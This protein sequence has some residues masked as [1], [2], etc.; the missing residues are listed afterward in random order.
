MRASQTY[1]FGYTY[2]DSSLQSTGNN[3]SNSNASSVALIGMLL[4]IF[5]TTCVLVFGLLLVH[6]DFTYSFQT[7]NDKLARRK[8]IA[9]KVI[10]VSDVW[11]S[12]LSSPTLIFFIQMG[13]SLIDLYSFW[14]N[15]IFY[16]YKIARFYFQISCIR[17]LLHLILLLSSYFTSQTDLTVI[18]IISIPVIWQIA[19]YILKFLELRL[20]HMSFTNLTNP[21]MVDIHLRSIMDSIL[22]IQHSTYLDTE[23][24]VI[25]ESILNRHRDKCN[26]YKVLGRFVY[27]KGSI[28]LQ[29]QEGQN[30]RH[31]S[32]CSCKELCQ[33]L[34]NI[35]NNQAIEVRKKLIHLY[36][37]ENYLESKNKFSENICSTFYYLAYQVEISE[38]PMNALILLIE[39]EII[40]QKKLSLHYQM[41]LADLKKKAQTRF[42]NQQKLK[43]VLKNNLLDGIKYDF[44]LQNI[45]QNL[46]KCLNQLKY[47]NN[48]LSNDYIDL[49]NLHEKSARLVHDVEE[50]EKYFLYV[51]QINPNS[52]QLQYYL[53][54]YTHIF[55][56]RICN[57]QNIIKSQQL[58][59]VM[60]VSELDLNICDP[61]NCILFVSLL[62]EIGQIKLVTRNS[63]KVIGKPPS[64]LI[65]HSIN[66]IIPSFIAKFHDQIIKNVIKNGFLMGSNDTNLKDQNRYQFFAKD[67]KN[68][69]FPIVLQLKLQIFGKCKD[70]GVSAIIQRVS[71][72]SNQYI[73]IDQ[74]YSLRGKAFTIQNITKTLYKICFKKVLGDNQSKLSGL[75]INKL[76]PLMEVLNQ[77]D[78]D[79]NKIGTIMLYPQTANH[80]N[81]FKK[82]N[83]MLKNGKDI[84]WFFMFALASNCGMLDIDI[85][86][87]IR[88]TQIGEIYK[89]IEITRIKKIY[90]PG[91]RLTSMSTLKQELSS[92]MGVSIFIGGAQLKKTF[93]IV[94]QGE[95]GQ[96]NQSSFRKFQRLA[97]ETKLMDSKDGQQSFVVDKTLLPNKTKIHEDDYQTTS[98][99]EN[100]EIKDPV[101]FLMKSNPSI[102]DAKSFNSSQ[103]LSFQ[104]NKKVD[105]NIDKEKRKSNLNQKNGQMQQPDKKDSI[106][107]Q[108]F[109][110]NKLE[111]ANSQSEKNYSKEQI[112]ERES[113]ESLYE[114]E[115][116]KSQK[117]ANM[118]NTLINNSHKLIQQFSILDNQEQSLYFHQHSYL[119]QDQ[120]SES[121]RKHLS[122]NYGS[123]SFIP[124]SK[125]QLHQDID[126][127]EQQYTQ[128]LKEQNF[129]DIQENVQ[130]LNQFKEEIDLNQEKCNQYQENSIKKK[131]YQDIQEN[132]VP[133]VTVI[134][135]DLQVIETTQFQSKSELDRIQTYQIENESTQKQNQKQFY[136]ESERILTF[137]T[138]IDDEKQNQK[139]IKQLNEQEKKTDKNN[140]GEIINGSMQNFE[141]SQDKQRGINPSLNSIQKGKVNLDDKNGYIENYS[142][143]FKNNETQGQSERILTYQSVSDIQTQISN[144]QTNK[145][146]SEIDPSSKFQQ[147]KFTQNKQI[148]NS[149]SQAEKVQVN[150]KDKN[151]VENKLKT[152]N[153]NKNTLHELQTSSSDDSSS[154]ESDSNQIQQ[155]EYRE[156]SAIQTFTIL[157]YIQYKETIQNKNQNQNIL[158]NIVNEEI[159]IKNQSQQN[160]IASQSKSQLPEK[161]SDTKEI[162]QVSNS[163]VQTES[164][165]NLK[166]TEEN[167]QEQ[168]KIEQ[169]NQNE[170]TVNSQHP[171][172]SSFQDHQKNKKSFQKI[173]TFNPDIDADRTRSESHQINDVQSEIQY[174]KT[175]DHFKTYDAIDSQYIKSNTRK[176]SSD[177]Q[178]HF[179]FNSNQQ[180][181]NRFSLLSQNIQNNEKLIKLQEVEIDQSDIIEEITQVQSDQAAQHNQIYSEKNI[182]KQSNELSENKLDN[183]EFFDDHY[184]EHENKEIDEELND[185]A[186]IFYQENSYQDTGSQVDTFQEKNSDLKSSKVSQK[187]F[188][189]KEQDKI[190]KQSIK[191]LF[192]VQKKNYVLP[193][194]LDNTNQDL[195]TEDAKSFDQ[196]SAQNDN[197]N[198]EED[199][200]QHARRLSNL[201]SQDNENYQENRRR[202][203]LHEQDDNFLNQGSNTYSRKSNKISKFIFQKNITVSQTI[204][205][206]GYLAFFLLIFFTLFV[207]F[208]LLVQ[209]QSIQDIIP[210]LNFGPN[211]LYELSQVIMNKEFEYLS[212]Y[213]DPSNQQIY[214]QSSLTNRTQT[215]LNQFRETLSQAEIIQSQNLPSQSIINLKISYFDENQSQAPQLG[216]IISVF[217]H[218]FLIF[219]QYTNELNG[220][221]PLKIVHLNSQ[222]LLN[223]IQQITQYFYNWTLSQLDQTRI[224]LQI[225]TY[226][227]LT[228]SGLIIFVIVPIYA[229]LQLLK[230]KIMQQFA[231]YSCDVIN[232]RN[233]QIDEM[234]IILRKNQ[235]RNEGNSEKQLRNEWKNIGQTQVKKK[236]I[237]RTNNLKL[238]NL[239]LF[240]FSIICLL[241]LSIY[242]LVNY[243]MTLNFL[244]EYRLFINELSILQNSRAQMIYANAISFLFLNE[245]IDQLNFISFEKQQNT[246]DQI[247]QQYEASIQN[248]SNFQNDFSSYLR[249]QESVQY[250]ILIDPLITDTC[251]ALYNIKN[252]SVYNS[253]VFQIDFDQNSCEQV[254]YGI[255]SQG[256][257][258]SLKN[259]MLN[260]QDIW[261]FIQ[262]N[263]N[264]SSEQLVP[265]FQILDKSINISQ[266][267]LLGDFI[268]LSFQISTVYT[269]QVIKLFFNYLDILQS[270]LLT[271]SL[272]QLLL[273]IIF[274]WRLF[275]KYIQKEII[276]VKSFYSL[277][278]NELVV[279]NNY[280][281]SFIKSYYKK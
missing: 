103:R 67:N 112:F 63:E 249:Y 135:D 201:N 132:K 227:I 100:F 153:Q 175:I 131:S 83:K 46:F 145:N 73:L 2:I 108:Q 105:F 179:Q 162:Q 160:I 237:S 61:K 24:G 127:D 252:L 230:E 221:E 234:L 13:F 1:I 156:D 233:M 279:N 197:E 184:D 111:T 138:R 38:S 212:Q 149:N 76:I 165:K 259:M 189:T 182:L 226:S 239:G 181:N 122:F 37:N 190:R 170:Q 209:Q 47:I 217:E 148:I 70:F 164:S 119:D 146:L 169:N 238:W 173:Q 91:D 229:R 186:K 176:L 124:H 21:Q 109:S 133:T 273:F 5:N 59:N 44:L 51:Y 270:C 85:N 33:I 65:S 90:K 265:N 9:S 281:Y 228:I 139:S 110:L 235:V 177:T 56:L 125:R 158:Q 68:Y 206:V 205:K 168:L 19:T 244:Q 99:D 117:P 142:S 180:Q 130:Q 11:I 141:Q 272:I 167:D 262:I 39:Y 25:F 199:V 96:H 275:I 216:N 154:K 75:D 77:D 251:E 82:N 204:S 10:V 225:G 84:G 195:N 254:K 101:Q 260:T 248:L 257:I 277:L 27:S 200:N 157:D 3:T 93:E 26:Q 134:N 250:Q 242:P 116:I 115:S 120:K 172:I 114:Q 53:N 18:L 102:K 23:K 263:L 187:K 78:K 188:I 66:S 264:K 104:N 269:Q 35:D 50:L 152:Q 171:S 255:L 95:S 219:W 72:Q 278:S 150:K 241:L 30:Q 215:Q 29:Q 98:S 137:Q 274:G 166:S 89:E 94:E 214:N 81:I 163:S 7:K 42:D 62:Q 106:N 8:S 58:D 36:L 208:S 126:Q 243:F 49:Y 211:M 86:L 54:A 79:R 14:R 87:K 129:N 194:N 247:I 271:Y 224:Y 12:V 60:Q 144:Q 159:N 121:I 17:L 253:N 15:M 258:I 223:D 69:I 193:K 57:I 256:I 34:K 71:N 222:M 232:K 16:D 113:K 128:S 246:T 74:K 178:S 92:R 267:M 6:H 20:P 261:N 268:D 22:N 45:D 218:L 161:I 28:S 240:V 198:L 245:Q 202:S 118:R 64:E 236:A 143:L 151:S 203:L 97:K 220:Q 183:S 276:I 147:S 213:L 48:Y 155:V 266:I 107:L 210:Y 4:S 136:Q 231:T 32:D 196:D 88:R 43:S 280:I 207:F 123:H 192:Q 55:D 191:M 52:S 40:H 31:T 41:I 80:C 174:H 140:F 185:H